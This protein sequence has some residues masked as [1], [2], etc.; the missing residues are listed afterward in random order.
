MAAMEIVVSGR[1][2]MRHAV[3][4][5]CYNRTPEQL[6]LS[7]QAL[8]S[9]LAQDIGPMDIY[10]VNNGSTEPTKQWLN[11]LLPGKDENCVQAVHYAE[12]RSPLLI[13]NEMSRKI[14]EHYDYV[15]GVPND[16]ILPPNAYRLMNEWPRGFIS[17]TPVEAGSHPEPVETA[18]AVSECTPMCVMLTRKWAHDAIVAKDGY[19]F[20]EKMFL[21]A[22]DCDLALRMAACGIRGVQLDIPFW[23]Y[24]SAHWR[25]LPPLE[26]R[27]ETL[28]ADA[29]R[30]YFKLKWGFACDSPE[31]GERGRD[32]NFR[33][34]HAS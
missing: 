22:S 26:G 29:D 32:I 12:N 31:Y 20:D 21:Y 9:V 15:L 18:R 5:L 34:E 11:S 16:V 8:D 3:L 1:C 14:Y 27:K 24:R 30:A 6:E 17:A 10:I 13:A 4:F 33:G 28:K 19:F 7:Q 23:H 2:E 25:L